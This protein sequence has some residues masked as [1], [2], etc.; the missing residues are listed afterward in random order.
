MVKPR[1]EGRKVAQESLPR[2][3]SQILGRHFFAAFSF[4]LF[5]YLPISL[6]KRESCLIFQQR[7]WLSW[8]SVRLLCERSWVRIPLMVLF[9]LF[10]LFPR[11]FFPSLPLKN[12]SPLSSRFSAKKRRRASR[13]SGGRPVVVCNRPFSLVGNGL[14]P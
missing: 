7:P 4:G 9:A 12:P 5:A 1:Y 13:T 11:C 14:G 10:C 6:N 3:S 8:W 2:T